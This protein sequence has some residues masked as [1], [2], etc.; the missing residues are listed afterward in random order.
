M[1]K[2]KKPINMAKNG[3][4]LSFVNPETGETTTVDIKEDYKLITPMEQKAYVPAIA[5]GALGSASASSI[6]SASPYLA[7]S[8]P[9][10]AMSLPIALTVG[11]LGL[12]LYDDFTGK[13]R[14]VSTTN[15]TK[16]FNDYTQDSDA[17]R[18][19]KPIIVSRIR[20]GNSDRTEPIGNMYINP[21]LTRSRAVDM[22]SDSIKGEKKPVTEN[23]SQG[24]S[25]KKGSSNSEHDQEPDQKDKKGGFV[26][27]FKE[28]WSEQMSGYPS[29]FGRSIGRFLGRT[30]KFTSKALPIAVG[31]Y[32]GIRMYNN[33]NS[34]DTVRVPIQNPNTV[35][36]DTTHQYTQKPQQLSVTPIDSS[37]YIIKPR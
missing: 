2:Y 23:T 32:T 3:R 34:P 24:E 33:W 7:A 9:A 18:V 37:R 11:S 25:Q 22:A 16:K 13:G 10:F 28:G 6:G 20:V 35:V 17:T 12:G 19:S 15:L 27:G 29:K 31:T 14:P 36:S 26:S 30:T 4:S 1:I 21:S 8:L 5:L